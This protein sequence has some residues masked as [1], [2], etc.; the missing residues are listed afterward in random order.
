MTD[1]ERNCVTALRLSEASANA[2]LSRIS[3]LIGVASSELIRAG[4][5][6]EVVESDDPL[7]INA[8]ITYVVSQMGNSESERVSAGEAFRL[9]E[10]EIRKS[11]M[12]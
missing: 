7:I 10:D 2:L 3:L 12:K 4:V 8:K 5:S 11:E 1:L 6:E 9:M